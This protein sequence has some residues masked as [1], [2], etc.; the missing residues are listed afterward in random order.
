MKKKNSGIAYV[1]IFG[2]DIRA[3]AYKYFT[4][5]QSMYGGEI[6]SSEQEAASSSLRFQMLN[7]SADLFFVSGYL[8]P[9]WKNAYEKGLPYVVCEADVRSMV[10]DAM[11]P[12]RV[13]PDEWH[14]K[15]AKEDE[16]MMLENAEAVI[17][18]SEDHLEYCQSKYNLPP[19]IVIHLRPLLK[20]I[21]FRPNPFKKMS[22]KNI[23]MCG[24]VSVKGGTLKY[25]QYYEMFQ[26]MGELGWKVHIITPR[27][28]Y[29]QYYDS[30]PHCSMH[31]P[32]PANEVFK[33]M[34][35]FP[36]G[37]VGYS[38]GGNDYSITCRPNKIWDYLG[39][40]IPTIALSNVTTPPEFCQWGMK[41]DSVEEINDF[42]SKSYNITREM[43]I[44][45]TIDQDRD[46]LHEF[47][48]PVLEK[49]LKDS[50]V[51]IAS[52]KESS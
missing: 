5:M 20:D 1:N 50:P 44:L 26:R 10:L 49:H 29:T 4:L 28:T 19:S 6:I 27:R 48:K 11:G 15:R 51:T 18:T 45:Q 25:K 33:Y 8:H 7:S 3:H 16:K 41:I 40:G 23:V 36:V 37:F 34:S 35:R 42:L 39:A 22:G 43:Q 32:I 14:I 52:M 31:E 12:D 13:S 47:L 38:T 21:L 9:E 30:L 24:G 2:R 46:R 17:F